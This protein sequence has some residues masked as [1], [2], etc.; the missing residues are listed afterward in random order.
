ME[1][2]RP[3][4]AIRSKCLD[5]SGGQPKEIRFCQIS[6]C[7]LWPYRMGKRPVKNI[8]GNHAL[9]IPQKEREE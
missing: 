7:T 9:S 3:L 8:Q 2:Q 6:T 4:K 1:I 5:C